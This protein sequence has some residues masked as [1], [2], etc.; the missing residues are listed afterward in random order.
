MILLA[1]S[2]NS[3]LT[4]VACASLRAMMPCGSAEIAGARYVSIAP[5]GDGARHAQKP[6]K[7][8]AAAADRWAL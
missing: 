6:A 5:S 3:N 1:S 2:D 7:S 4:S 8:G